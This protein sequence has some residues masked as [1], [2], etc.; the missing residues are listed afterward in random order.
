MQIPVALDN[1][2]KQISE[3][4][5]TLL[6]KP[7][8][9]FLLDIDEATST[10]IQN[11]FGMAVYSV[12]NLPEAI[13]NNSFFKDLTKGEVINGNWKG[14]IQFEKPLSNSLI[15][16][17]NYYFTNEDNAVN[18]GLINLIKFLDAYLPKALKIE[19]HV[20]VI[21]QDSDKIS[22]ERWNIEYGRLVTEIKKLRDYDINIEL[23]LTNTI[24]R[25]KLISNYVNGRTDQGFDVFH[26]TD[27]E[28]VKTD[29]EFE[30]NEIFIN[31]DNNGTKHFQ[32]VS[33]ALDKLE[34]IGNEVSEYIKAKGN[35][36]G[37]LIY[38]CNPDKSIK[39]RLLN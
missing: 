27:T 38:G 16:S 5:S 17:D 12:Q 6:D 13:F 32:S 30:H 11:D 9:I 36:K 10:R 3:D 39:N 25:R 18:R 34:N 7:R 29:N 4:T 20:T 28:K 23:V 24:H 35:T 22:P 33:I 19:Y 37:K 8:S 31:I 1:F 2:F 14:L 21:A 15:I 26:A